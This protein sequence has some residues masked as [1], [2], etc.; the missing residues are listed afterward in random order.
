[1]NYK[2][3]RLI[4]LLVLASIHSLATAS[5]YKY[6]LETSDKRD[7]VNLTVSDSPNQQALL[8]LHIG[9]QP[10]AVPTEVLDNFPNIQVDSFKVVNQLSQS[11]LRQTEQLVSLNFAYLAPEGARNG[12][13][14]FRNRQ[15]FMA[16]QSN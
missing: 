9:G 14:Y 15:Y 1:M 11:T 2:F 6:Q 4:S 7:T 3:R 8:E 16:I 13:I 5:E 12:A 10:V